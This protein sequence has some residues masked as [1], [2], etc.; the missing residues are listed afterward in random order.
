[1]IVSGIRRTFKTHHVY[2]TIL[3]SHSVKWFSDMGGGD[4]FKRG[5]RRAPSVT[6]PKRNAPVTRSRN[7]RNSPPPS[8]PPPAKLDPWEEVTDKATGQS[9]YFFQRRL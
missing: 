6:R 1:M 2:T 8:A 5:M 9:K 3:K 7:V 4:D